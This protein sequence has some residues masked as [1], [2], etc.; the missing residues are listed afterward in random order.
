MKIY[1]VKI[2]CFWCTI[3]SAL[4]FND[5]ISGTTLA[6]T[7]YFQTTLYSKSLSVYFW[8]SFILLRAL[9]AWNHSICPSFIDCFSSICSVVPSLC[10]ISQMTFCT[11]KRKSKK[12]QYWKMIKH[13]DGWKYPHNLVLACPPFSPS[14]Q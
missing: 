10:L 4:I 12:C 14:P 1:E 9:P 2:T 3:C 7:V 5:K 6:F 13:C 8:S 11:C